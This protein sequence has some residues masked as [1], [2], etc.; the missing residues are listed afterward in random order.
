MNQI[1]QVTR[2][3]FAGFFASPAAWLFLGA[4]LTV[5][6]FVFFWVE[7]FFARNIADARPLFAWMP[8]LLI[9]LAGAI[10]MRMW[11][12]ERRAGTL[13]LLLT[14]PVP[15]YQL[16]LGKF[17]ACLGLMTIALAL[18]LP[19]PLT[20]SLLGPLDWGPVL[21]GY[22]ATLFLAA[23]Y[24]AI[25]L[26]VSARSANP[27]VSLIG[28]VALCGLFYLL[29]A[30]ALT[31]LFG[32]RVAEFLSLLGSG[33]RF[34]S[35]TRGVLDVRDLYYYLS[36]VG[37]FLAL[38][39][40]ALEWLRWA[41]NPTTA[42][43]R[44]WHWLIGLVVANLLTAN[45]W[46]AP[47]DH[48]RIDLTQGRL[49]SLS[50]T[51]RAY[52]AQLREPLLIRGYFSAQTHPLLT[53]LVPR[54]RDLLQE[55][56]VASGGRARVEIIDPREHPE[57]EREANE[58]YGIKPV[59]FQFASKYQASVINS[60]FNIVVQYGDRYETLDFRDL[61]EVKTRGETDLSV[62]LRNPEYD[63]TQ[64]IKKVLYD[65][66]GGG[67][68]FDDLARPL[69]FRGY[70]SAN[71]RLPEVLRELRQQLDALLAERSAQ[72]EG[73][74]TVEIQD[75]EAGDGALARRL[76]NEFGFRPMVASLL[77]PE[78][79][80]FYLT[81]DDGERTVTIPLPEDFDR[82]GLER[83]LDAGIKRFAHG[84]M[85]TIAL[86]TPAP[87]LSPF[88]A[89]VGGARFSQLRTALADQ[90]RVVDAELAS[91]QVP[92][93]ADL[94]VVVAPE[95]LDHKSLFAI[96]Q[97]LMRGGTVLL[98]TA[99]F[100]IDFEQALSAR[101]HDSGLNDWLAHYGL[102][103]Q[104]RMVLDPQNAAFPI[105]VERPLGGFMVREVQLVDYP[106]FVDVRAD[107]M[108][109]ASG[110]I[111][112]LD[113]VTLTWAAPIT[114]DATQQGERR[115]LPLLHS[116]P[117][118]WTADS[119]DIQPDYRAHGALGFAR[120]TERGRQL[121]AVALEGRFASY[122]TGKPSPL[123]DT[124]EPSAADAEAK[125]A[126]KDPHERRPV[127]ARVIEHSPA[128]AR[129]LLFASNTFLDDALLDLAAAG[130]GTRYLKPLELIENAI[131]WSLEDRGLL[132]LR[133]RAHFSRTLVPL[134]RE[135]QIFWEYFNYFLAALGL[136][137]L[138][139]GRMYWQRRA[140]A[141]DAR[142]LGTPVSGAEG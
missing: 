12:E 22:V 83:A 60:Y 33:S 82:A 8:A 46:L 77:E 86:H 131:D 45:L 18:T 59:P 90:H 140:V 78:P 139:L 43:H 135:G 66:R 58:K 48:W 35:I 81:L 38:N 1:W 92:A 14:L 118:A 5:T 36:L 87:A 132:A 71:E 51:S 29:G 70:F 39:V 138:W 113:Q 50:A 27:L 117:D 44:H 7:T 15:G 17:L 31:A 89:G 99:P 116:S 125:P 25:G 74:F 105:P 136:T 101:P 108:E 34:A 91:G 123:L 4:F 94:L 19:L 134:R 97:F 112:G 20:V 41:N 55:Y 137:A 63:L 40:L 120:G 47:L 79:F 24:L 114:V 115:V 21:G 26:F 122:F 65:Y 130:L 124:A 6:L 10:T 121:L 67:R 84:T 85:K 133:G 93:D 61:I 37:A 88:G 127:I 32:Q 111:A 102:T 54:L 68:L 9:F 23:A 64:A 30:Q 57:L 3:E 109:T 2:K 80:W 104:P 69:T 128:S 62:E 129:I 96:D 119:L 49:Y 106:Y 95:R 103:V 42:V 76:E 56:A 141:R 100:A 11:S 28:T 16:V 73:K 53:P 52:L 13:E 107:G 75:P 142:I 98:A 126:D 72:A 110:L